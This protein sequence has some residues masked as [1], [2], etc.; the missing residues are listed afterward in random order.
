MTVMPLVG[1]SAA[2][3]DATGPDPEWSDLAERTEALAMKRMMDQQ[4][5]E[6]VER[7]G[8]SAAALADGVHC[9]VARDPMWGYWNKALG[10]CTTVSDDTVLEAVTRARER[11]IPAFA[12][13]VQPRA[14]PDD[15]AAVTDRHRLTEG[16]MFVKL[17]GPPEPRAVETDLRIARLTADDAVAF[18]HVMSIGFG[19]EET[20]ESH[21]LFDAPQYFEG[22]WAAYGAYDGDTLVAV[23]R[24]C[25]VPETDAVALFGAATVPAGRNRGA[26]GALM[27]ARI[28]EARDRGVRFASAETWLESPGNP[29]PSQ[30]NMRRAGL[31]EVHT[32]PNWVWRRP[33]PD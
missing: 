8:I 23:A 3:T 18:T 29:N 9:V 24:M 15:W 4:P 21:A 26:Q 17:F 5:G 7:L 28:R 31:T 11:Q 25:V 22:D 33:G 16:T 13:Q 6:T 20:P 12:L 2:M 19:F 27:D 1:Q 32:R 30:H 14:L 10:F